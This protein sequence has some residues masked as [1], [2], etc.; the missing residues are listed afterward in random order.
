ML[1]KRNLIFL[2]LLILGILLLS[3]CFLNPPATEGILKGQVIVPEQKVQAKD[4]TGQALPDA[5]VN[6]IDL[7]TGEIIA[8][9]TTD[10][11]GYYQVFVSAGGPYLLEAIKDGV[12]VQQI[13]PQVEVGEEYDLGT[14]DC[15]T[16]AVALIAQAMLDAEDYPNNL[17]D[18]NLTDIETDTNFNDVMSEVCS[19]IQA[20]EDPTLS[21]LVQQAVEDFLYPPEPAPTP[22]PAPIPTYTVTFDSQGGSAVVSQTVEQDAKV[23][24]PTVPTKTD[25]AFGG[26]YKESGCTN[27]WNFDTDTVTANVTL[28]AKWIT[29]VHNITQDT[30]YTAIQLALDDANSNDVIEVADGTYTETIRFNSVKIIILRSVNGQSFTTIIGDDNSGTVIC[31]T[32]SPDGTTLEGFTI[33]HNTS[34]SGR[35]ISVNVSGNLAVNNCTIYNNKNNIIPTSYGGGIGNSGTLTITG[36]TI[37]NNLAGHGGGILNYDS[38]ILTINGSTIKNNSANLIGGGIY[39]EGTLTITESI[40]SDNRSSVILP[41]YF[42]GG[43]HNEKGLLTIIGSTIKNNSSDRGGGIEIKSGTVTIGGGNVS[44]YNIICGNTTEGTCTITNQIYPDTYPNNYI[45]VDCTCGFAALRNL[46]VSINDAGEGSILEQSFHCDITS[47]TATVT[48]DIVNSY[49]TPIANCSGT[50]ITVNGELVNSGSISGPVSLSEGENLITIIVTA[51]DGTT[52]K[53][54]I[55]TVTRE[56]L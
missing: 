50:T 23:T 6:I 36:S 8:T 37:D 30:Y 1:K 7:A 52:T 56:T 4:L 18:I 26:W 27:A 31:T 5:T 42:G 25:Y 39:N 15:A 40:I 46:S 2:S 17:T 19:I 53:T 29:S 54:Y 9:T 35:G 10:A 47:Y 48:N 51:K 3:S 33:T 12:K 34:D 24:E 38:G 49:I 14:A 43:I 28:Y 11:N 32:D 55:V 44:D 20:G 13:T 45:C 16:T 41:G 22:T 21:A